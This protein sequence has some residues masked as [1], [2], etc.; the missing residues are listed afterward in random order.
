MTSEPNHAAE[1]YK[2]I[3]GKGEDPLPPNDPSYV[4]LL[5]GTP[6]KDPILRMAQ[7]IELATSESVQLLT[8][9]R[10]NGKSTQLLRLEH[11]LRE[12]GCEV[13]RLD[14]IE[15]VS[16]TKPIEISDFLL[17][18]L[19]A[20][21]VELGQTSAADPLIDGF[22]ARLWKFLKSEIKVEDMDLAVDGN[23]G[24]AKVGTRIGLRLKTEE[25]FKKKVQDHLRGRVGRLVEQAEEF[26]SAIVDDVRKRSRDPHRKVVV[27]LDS[28]EQLRGVGMEAAQLYGSVVEL[29]SGQAAS[30]RFA[31]IHIVY[32]VPPYLLSLAPN[33]GLMYG[34]QCVAMWPNLHV[35]N[36]QGH[37]DRSGLARMRK[38]IDRR[39]TDW[40][41]VLTPK[42]LQ[43]LA[44]ASGGDLRD[45]FRLVR[46]AALSLGIARRDEP[47]A[48]L[49]EDMLDYVE[50]SLRNE[51]MPTAIDDARWLLSIH[52]SKSPSLPSAAELPALARFFDS[53]WIMNYQNGE[54]WFD[55]HPLLVPVVEKLAAFGAEH[56]EN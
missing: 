25:S 48:R 4:E 15:F 11:L 16:M 50:Q 42:Q 35:R 40:R 21:T 28:L 20:L 36:L 43:R 10:G 12:R 23:L 34:G 49:N 45:F 8:G 51:L 2:A 7:R 31:K 55:I 19:A 52:Q 30:L 54:P 3:S 5:E 22:L 46:E 9:F 14:M 6:S 47:R 38:L 27:L 53:N 37:P 41:A 26:I 39:Y 32:T 29:F 24:V 18:F 1:L 44:T 17:S 33:V 13:F 56:P